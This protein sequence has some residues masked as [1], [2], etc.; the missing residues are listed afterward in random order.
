MNVETSTKQQTEFLYRHQVAPGSTIMLTVALPA[1]VCYSSCSDLVPLLFFHF[2][3]SNTD[4]FHFIFIFYLLSFVLSVLLSSC[5]LAH[6]LLLSLTPPPASFSLFFL[7]SRFCARAP[8]L[9]SGG[10]SHCGKFPACRSFCGSLVSHR[11]I[12]NLDYI[13][14]T[15]VPQNSIWWELIRNLILSFYITSHSQV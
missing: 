14:D 4:I 5:S 9:K 6:F 7:F 1:F 10:E 12:S 13:Y 11:W 8:F 2:L 15:C 3:I